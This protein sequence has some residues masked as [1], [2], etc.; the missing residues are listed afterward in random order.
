[1]P[2]LEIGSTLPDVVFGPISRT[3]LALYAGAS[4]DHD[5]VHIDIDFARDA[6]HPDV[7]AHGMLS[8]GVLSRLVTQWCG[9][10]RLRSLGVRFLA[11][12]HVHDVIT[13]TGTVSELF[14]EGGADY[15]KIQL[16]V[17]TH[18]GRRTLTGEAVVALGRP[19]YPLSGG[20]QVRGASASRPVRRTDRGGRQRSPTLPP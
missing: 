12:T 6:G 10:Q 7:F 2:Q 5:P 14:E 19:G 8:F 20:G 3:V 11:I 18:D 4:G 1:M 15:A 17:T 13:C 16:A 9:P